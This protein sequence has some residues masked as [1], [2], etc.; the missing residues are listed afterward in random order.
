MTK[1]TIEIF[2]V[3]LL[4][5]AA[6]PG[7]GKGHVELSGRVTFSDNG[8]PMTHG[9][10][11]FVSATSLARGEIDENGYYTV[12]SYGETDGLLPDTYRVFF[13]NTEISIGERGEASNK[14]P[15]MKAVIDP[16]Y[17][18]PDTS[19]LTLEVDKTTRQFDIKVDRAK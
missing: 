12:G 11:A 15:I 4:C 17:A 10:V 7:C 14:I 16:K 19:G 9:T 1:R 3:L 6:L 5:L 8:E 2:V 13:S 18:S